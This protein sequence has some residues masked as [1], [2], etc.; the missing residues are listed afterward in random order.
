MT[1]TETT[2]A[3]AALV[4]IDVAKL[5]NDVL[6][7]VPAAR[8]R[9]RLTAT[10]RRDEHDR[11]VAELHALGHPVLVGLKPTTTTVP[12]PGAWC[13]PGSTCG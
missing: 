11:L 3:K 8:R 1:K 5:R 7:E 12:W 6:I 10:N 2:P 9:R 4:A 13:R